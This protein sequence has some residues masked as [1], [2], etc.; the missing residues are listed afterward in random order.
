MPVTQIDDGKGVVVHLVG[1]IEK[2]DWG[3][4]SEAVDAALDHDGGWSAIDLSKAT[5][6][7]SE[8]LGFLIQL[9]SRSR[10]RGRM[11]VIINPSAFVQGVLEATRLDQWFDIFPDLLSAKQRILSGAPHP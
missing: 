10:L 6:I 11:A 5:F 2:E 4:T 9:V 3:A 8:G 7:S 1:E